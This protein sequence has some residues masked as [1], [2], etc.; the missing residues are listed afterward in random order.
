[1]LRW[2]QSDQLKSLFRL[3]KRQQFF[4]QLCVFVLF[5]H[6][7]VA[8][9]FSCLYQGYHDHEKFM[10]SSKYQ[11]ATLVLCPLKKRINLNQKNQKQTAIKDSKV[12]DYQAYQK[13]LA[14]QKEKLL[15]K[16]SEVKSAE[17]KIVKA[18][19]KKDIKKEPVIKNKQKPELKIVDVEV[20]SKK[21]VQ[22]QNLP[23]QAA[24]KV[25]ES[26]KEEVVKKELVEEKAAE[27]VLQNQM[28]LQDV[29][30]V[31][32]EQLDS[33]MIERLIQQAVQ[34][35]FK[36]PVGIAKDIS[37]EVLVDVSKDG[38]ASLAK[39]VRSSGIV[40]YDTSARAALYKTEF[41]KEVWNKTISIVLGQ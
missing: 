3:N 21:E 11:S 9:L 22:A 28:N 31:G 13:Q 40:A 41:P 5:G 39:V 32:Y 12:I 24:K 35:F 23:A 10:V 26:K 36:P 4:L 38:R 25:P 14:E 7:I 33:L 19:T 15:A 20:A 37:C 29:E 34:T 1:M 18:Q 8:I 6:F 27:E 2:L 17:Q 16:K 30:F